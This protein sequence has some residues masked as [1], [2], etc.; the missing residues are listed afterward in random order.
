MDVWELRDMMQLLTS[1]EVRLLP[2]LYSMTFQQ[3]SDHLEKLLAADAA[4]S[5]GPTR[6]MR[7][8]WRSLRG[9]P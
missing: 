9:L 1:G 3:L 8:C 6:T 7:R 5:G 2:V 4:L